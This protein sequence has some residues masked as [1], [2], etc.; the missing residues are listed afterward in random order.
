ML[1]LSIALVVMTVA[2]GML[3]GTL[4]STSRV[5]PLQ[6]ESALAALAA[7]SQ[8]EM[9][10]A[11]PFG[12]LFA[13]Y[14]DTGDDD[15]SGPDTAPGSL[16]RVLGLRSPDGVDGFVGRIRFPGDGVELREDVVR[17]ELGMPRDL[18][19][20][21]TIAAVDVAND[22]TLLPVEIELRWE[23]LSGVRSMRLHTMFISP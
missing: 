15:P 11:E 8:L 16:F 13:R 9:M 23:S 1:E 19:G 7:R 17:I 2:I 6:R 22:Y 12:E 18:T 21:G 14:N 3:S 10:R 20:N 5:A 4:T